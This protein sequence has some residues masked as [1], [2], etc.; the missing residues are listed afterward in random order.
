MWS[1]IIWTMCLT[2]KI[3]GDLLK[4]RPYSGLHRVLVK[5]AVNNVVPEKRSWRRVKFKALWVRTWST[6]G[7]R[8]W[9]V[10]G[11]HIV[12]WK[13]R[14]S[15]QRVQDTSWIQLDSPDENCMLEGILPHWTSLC[16]D[17]F[18]FVENFT[19]SEGVYL[20][21]CMEIVFFSES[22]AGSNLNLGVSQ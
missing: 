14:R 17:G 19:I 16:W 10:C 18:L 3:W 9:R 11:A 12:A 21:K 7:R 20:G 1:R 15:C 8:F 6:G 2:S 4:V 13:P 5:Q 22:D